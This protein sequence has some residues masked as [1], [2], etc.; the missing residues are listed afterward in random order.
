[1]VLEATNANVASPRSSEGDPNPTPT[2]PKSAYLPLGSPGQGQGHDLSL[3]PTAT[4]SPISSL[5]KKHRVSSPQR[6]LQPLPT[7]PEKDDDVGR[8][9]G[10][11]RSSEEREVTTPT[12]GGR[13]R[14]LSPEKESALQT[15]DDVILQAEQSMD[16]TG[17]IFGSD[18][19]SSA[20]STADH[21]KVTEEGQAIELGSETSSSRHRPLTPQSGDFVRPLSP[22]GSS[23]IVTVSEEDEEELDRGQ[24]R[25]MRSIEDSPETPHR[26]IP[27]AVPSSDS[28]DEVVIVSNAE[29]TLID[30]NETTTDDVEDDFGAVVNEDAPVDMSHVSVVVVGGDGDANAPLTPR[31]S[32][33]AGGVLSGGIVA[34]N[35][36]GELSDL[37][38][39]MSSASHT[40]S[41]SKASSSMLN[42]GVGQPNHHHHNQS[43]QLHTQPDPH[44]RLHPNSGMT[45]PTSII[46][47]GTLTFAQKTS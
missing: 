18:V 15:L 10:Q 47:E 45:S 41:E 33:N 43:R 29:T 11:Q 27:G 12:A 35:G 14:E 46:L 38:R 9:Q 19:T 13:G 6:A 28:N 1:M 37:S 7:S 36:M 20:A 30:N 40:S 17:S 32:S 5:K 4:K 39:S 25:M 34:T 22:Q 16:D 24:Q 3:I 44:D 21:A 8:G 42:G 2:R 31:T 26:S 23:S